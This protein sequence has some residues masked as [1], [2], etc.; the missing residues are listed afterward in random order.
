MKPFCTVLPKDVR[1]RIF[2]RIDIF[3]FV[4]LMTLI[5]SPIRSTCA[6]KFVVCRTVGCPRPACLH[7]KHNKWLI[8]RWNEGKA[9]VDCVLHRYSLLCVYCVYTCISSDDAGGGLIIQQS[10]SRHMFHASCCTFYLSY[11]VLINSFIWKCY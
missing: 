1:I 11:S 7:C 8:L 10:M 2:V 4:L 6:A 3:F 5:T 9:N